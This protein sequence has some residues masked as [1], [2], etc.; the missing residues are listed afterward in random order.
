MKDVGRSAR[1][2]AEQR[3]DVVKEAANEMSLSRG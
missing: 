3:Q 1:E 2:F